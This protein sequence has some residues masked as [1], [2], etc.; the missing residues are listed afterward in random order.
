MLDVRVRFD[1]FAHSMHGA[2]TKQIAFGA[3]KRTRFLHGKINRWNPK[4]GGLE[5]DVPFN[6]VNFMFHAKV[7]GLNMPRMT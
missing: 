5:D 7:P 1:N 6:W 2:P 4:N 3:W